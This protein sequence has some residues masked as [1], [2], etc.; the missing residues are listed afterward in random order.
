VRIRRNRLV[1]RVRDTA[2]SANPLSV[3]YGERLPAEQL[4]VHLEFRPERMRHRQTPL[5]ECDGVLLERGDEGGVSCLGQL[6]LLDSS[7]PA[8]AQDSPCLPHASSQHVQW[9]R[10]RTRAAHGS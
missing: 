4:S 5:F 7:V 6:L 1:T 2:G 3:T 9:R 10:P 8:L